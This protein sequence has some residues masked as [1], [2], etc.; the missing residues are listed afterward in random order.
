MRAVINDIAYQLG[1]NR[2]NYDDLLAR[3]PDWD[4]EQLMS[5]V[6]KNELYYA[7]KGKTSMDLGCKAC[8]KLFEDYPDLP[9][10]IDGL[11]FCTV[12][13]DHMTPQNS[14][15]LHRELNL[16][17]KI[18]ALDISMGCSGFIYSLSVAHGLIHSGILKNI[19][20][21]NA[22]TF[23]NLIN[24]NDRSVKTVFSDGAAVTWV[25]ASDSFRGIQDITFGTMG[26]A[27]DTVW[28]PAGLCRMPNSAET[29]VERTDQSGNIRTLEQVHMDGMKLLLLVR[30]LVPKQILS[31]L[32]RNQ[33]KISDIDLFVFHQASKV[34]L[35]SLKKRLK[36]SIDKCFINFHSTGNTSSASIPIALKDAM[37]A[38]K[39]KIGD[40]I[41][42]SGFGTG[43][44][45]ASAIIKM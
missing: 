36:L 33:L 22:E 14:Y 10:I 5:L 12:T 39:L 37:E 44:S 45:W 6:G 31:L 43:F 40:K 26:S 30:S 41:L 16:P 18:F 23:S 4:R 2:V 29:S 42:M 24:E 3:H 21:I 9:D 15:I 25:S 17:K 38:G 11:I 1:S 8:L 20:I 28:I 34:A 13:P 32:Q 19:L 7:N 27:Y 35:D